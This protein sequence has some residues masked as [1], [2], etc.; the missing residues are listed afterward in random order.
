MGL[1]PRI[2][3]VMLTHNRREEVIRSLGQ[4]SRLPERPS[5]IVVDN[6]STDGTASAVR[7]E[8]PEAE[9]LELRENL[10]AAGRTLGVARV[11]TPYVAFCDDDTWWQSGSLRRA[12]ELFESHPRLAVITGRILVGPEEREDPMCRELEASPLPDEPGLPGYPLL[13]FMAGASAI[14][15]S[16]FLEAGGFPQRFFIGGEE[17][18][19]A[20]DLATRGWA[21]RYAPELVV[22]HHPS[23]RRDAK[24]RRSYLLRNALWA[25][26]LRR[27]LGS[28]LRKTLWLART[29][30]GGRA[31]VFGFGAALAGLPWVISQ[32][33][34][35][36]TEVEDRL[37]LLETWRS[38]LHNPG[39][40]D[41]LNLLNIIPCFLISTSR[42][43]D[44]PPARCA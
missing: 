20:V 32:R 10:G 27:P 21:M 13:G 29:A 9:V 41:I 1:D 12:V 24:T 33:C 30:P 43:T 31:A 26:W 35:I 39:P 14:R 36:P 3:T 22:H 8:F 17:E 2:S 16:A 44:C 42:E 15:R 38:P 19:L 40:A 28:A 7:Q 5:L 25:A 4:L 18:L 11:V 34:V 37:R 6:A 23:S